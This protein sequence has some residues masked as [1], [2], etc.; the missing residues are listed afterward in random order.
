MRVRMCS[1][2]CRTCAIDKRTAI[3]FPKCKVSGDAD[4]TASCTFRRVERGR[5]PCKSRERRGTGMPW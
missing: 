4:V 1:A 5:V 2:Y 3:A